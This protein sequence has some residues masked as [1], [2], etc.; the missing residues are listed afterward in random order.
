MYQ[1]IIFSLLTAQLF[2]AALACDLWA[3]DK[4]SA[5]LSK[6]ISI[7]AFHPPAGWR[8]KFNPGTLIADTLV[9]ALK[10][11][12]YTLLPPV[13]LDESMHDSESPEGDWDQMVKALGIGGGAK[14]MNDSAE[15]SIKMPKQMQAERMDGKMESMPMKKDSEDSKMM[16]DS[17]KPAMKPIMK[18]KKRLK[19]M[20]VN[21]AQILIRGSVWSFE[22]SIDSMENKGLGSDETARIKFDLQLIDTMTGR[23]IME[24]DVLASASG[25]EKPFSPDMLNEWPHYSEDFFKTSLGYSLNA[26]IAK[27]LKKIEKRLDSIPLEGQIIA[28]DDSRRMVWL[29]MGRDINVAV[30][31]I[32]NVYDIKFDWKDPD[33]QLNLGNEY[34]LQGAVK[35]METQDGVSRAKILAGDSIMPGQLVR[36]RSIRTP[37][38]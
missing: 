9:K 34:I 13:K 25:G 29:N 10:A 11:K 14:E 27:T 35:V 8:N 6:K 4:R 37:S 18:P 33:T 24:S 26:S 32:F 22:P 12:G 3:L 5:G 36:L 20:I 19:K 7:E 31:E 15:D 1:K 30:R 38:R 28:K 17:M 2:W 23:E 21:P 16:K